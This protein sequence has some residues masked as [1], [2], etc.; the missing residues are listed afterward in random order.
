MVRHSDMANCE[1][2]HHRHYRQPG[3]PVDDSPANVLI[4]LEQR[5]DDMISRRYAQNN[6]KPSTLSF[7]CKKLRNRSYYVTLNSKNPPP[8]GVL[9]KRRELSKSAPLNM[10]CSSE[11]DMKL[12]LKEFRNGLNNI[13][14]QTA[15]DLFRGKYANFFDRVICV[16]CRFPFEHNGMI[17]SRVCHPKCI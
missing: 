14:I 10:S 6:S 2:H 4:H 13:S 9:K 8:R 15:S 16:D 7:R 5:A 12:P 1:Q 3:T 11:P 17:V